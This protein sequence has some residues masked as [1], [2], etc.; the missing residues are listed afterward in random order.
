MEGHAEHCFDKCWDAAEG[1]DHLVWKGHIQ[2]EKSDDGV[3]RCK[4]KK[5]RRK[6]SSG[7]L[8]G[9]SVF[10]GIYISNRITQ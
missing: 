9:E 7:H 2:I 8:V 1:W 10:K 4:R 5:K 3:L 6:V